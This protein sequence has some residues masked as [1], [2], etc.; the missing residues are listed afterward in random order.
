[1]WEIDR[2]GSRDDRRAQLALA[3]RLPQKSAPGHSTMGSYR[4]RC[5]RG[6][7]Y[8]RNHRLAESRCDGEWHCARRQ[9]LQ[10]PHVALPERPLCLTD[11][12]GPGLAGFQ[13]TD[14][15]QARARMMRSPSRIPAQHIAQAARRQ[16]DRTRPRMCGWHPPDAGTVEDNMRQLAR[17]AAGS[18]TGVID[19][20]P[21][22]GS[23]TLSARRSAFR[24]GK[25]QRP[26]RSRPAFMIARHHPAKCE[27]RQ[28]A[29]MRAMSCSSRCRKRDLVAA[30]FEQGCFIGHL[31]QAY[32]MPEPRVIP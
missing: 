9:I 8:G 21:L 24:H 2:R 19:S 16:H 1:M 6:A 14:T 15:A 20:A 17:E 26:A 13:T 28:A 27:P 31:A 10:P 3:A 25:S 12:D 7:R 32:R 23:A 11:Q 22:R 29:R 5:D 18:R 30:G 4:A